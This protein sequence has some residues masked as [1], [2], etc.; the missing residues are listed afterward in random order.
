M[1]KHKLL[2]QKRLKNLQEGSKM[3]RKLEKKR[4]IEGENREA[5]TLSA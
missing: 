5:A 3:N 4:K 2:T 1:M